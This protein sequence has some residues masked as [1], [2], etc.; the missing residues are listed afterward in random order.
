M[1]GLD[2]ILTELEQDMQLEDPNIAYQAALKY[3]P[4]SQARI[5]SPAS[6][7]RERIL[8]KDARMITGNVQIP[9]GYAYVYM[10][11]VSGP[12][13]IDGL[14]YEATEFLNLEPIANARHAA[15]NIQATGGSV[16]LL[17]E[18]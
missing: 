7:P 4:I 16:R 13:T 15:I 9:E 3:F 17:G 2:Q 1:S 14:T 5:S 8:Q 10:K 6:E 12:V 11:V 18:Y